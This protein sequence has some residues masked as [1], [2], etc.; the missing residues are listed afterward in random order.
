MHGPIRDRLEDLLS[1]G[2]ETAGERDLEHLSQC[3]ECLAELHS[4]QTQASMLK[5]LR[6][7]AELEPAPGFYARVMQRIEERAKETIWAALA[8]SPL[9]SK[10][11][12]ASLTLVLVLGSYVIASE[13]RDG[14][15]MAGISGHDNVLVTGDAAQ[16]R[17][18]VLVNFASR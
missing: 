6:A 2:Q 9:F 17:N 14:H 7:H 3:R 18:A 13:T 1:Q 15:L 11:A 4:M 8:G 16:Q 10:F 5:S 12:Y